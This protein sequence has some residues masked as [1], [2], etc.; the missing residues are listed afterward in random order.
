MFVIGKS[1]T[2]PSKI[3][4]TEQVN[5]QSR[6]N[7]KKASKEEEKNKKNKSRD[8]TR[9]RSDKRWI[10]YFCVVAVCNTSQNLYI[11]NLIFLIFSAIK[12][13]CVD[14]KL[15]KKHVFEPPKGIFLPS[16]KWLCC[17]LCQIWAKLPEARPWGNASRQK[18]KF[19]A[20]LKGVHQS[21]I[22]PQVSGTS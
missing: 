20:F 18:G 16:S 12:Q 14:F 7:A 6:K 4:K 3:K 1:T 11:F 19:L 17:S 9:S 21:H 5:R 8:R 22:L 10:P 2:P 15:F 13:R